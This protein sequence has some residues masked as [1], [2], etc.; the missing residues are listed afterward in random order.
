VEPFPLSIIKEEFYAFDESYLSDYCRFMTL[1]VSMTSLNEVEN[2]F[3]MK[4]EF[5]FCGGD[6]LMVPALQ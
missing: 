5:E 3:D 4:V 2:E 1:I 6:C